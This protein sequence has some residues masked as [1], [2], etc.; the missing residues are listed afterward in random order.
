MVASINLYHCHP[1]YLKTPKKIRQFIIEL[2]R[3]IG[4]RR[5]GPALIERFAEG[6]LEGYSALQF[7]ETSSITLHFDELKNRAF[8]DIFTCK[9]F[10]F[11][12]AERFAK[13]FFAAK[14][15]TAFQF[16]RR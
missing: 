11:R 7:I 6:E 8:I 1:R 3:L 5:H 2:C 14:K 16:L 13:K 10:S 12:E 9:Y 15:S 4:M